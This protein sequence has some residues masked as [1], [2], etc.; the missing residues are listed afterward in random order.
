MYITLTQDKYFSL[1]LDE[2][3]KYILY[4]FQAS[5]I[6]FLK[7]FGGPSFDTR[8]KIDV[9]GSPSTPN[10][11]LKRKQKSKLLF[12]SA[13]KA[14]HCFPNFLKINSFWNRCMMG[15]VEVERINKLENK[16]EAKKMAAINLYMKIV[17]IP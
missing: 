13:G 10:N 14:I 2:N 7:S 6:E 9:S 16:F 3:I 8:R 15:H 17:E 11:W 4:V 1:L 5:Q 12:L